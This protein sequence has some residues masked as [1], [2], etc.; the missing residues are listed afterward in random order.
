MEYKL[1]NPTLRVVKI[2]D[3]INNYENG[4][5]F[6]EISTKLK[7]P[8]ST[9]SPIL[10][11]LE[12]T[13]FIEKNDK[14]CY[15]A[16]FKL[17]QLGL[18][19]SGRLDSLSMIKKQMEIVV[20]KIGEIVQFG[21]L[22]DNMV[23]YLEKVNSPDNIEIVSSVGKKIP[24]IYTALGKALLSGF[25]DAEI[26]EK[27]KDYEFVKYTEN[28]ITNIDRLLDEIHKVRERGYAVENQE[29]THNTS[30]VAVPIREDGII[31]G[32]MS[33]TYPI[34]RKT[35]DTEDFISKVLLEQKEIIEDIIKIQNLKLDFTN[36]EQ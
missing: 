33:A 32:A 19:Y 29:F 18:S 11:T 30:C 16:S 28:S 25:S 31:K 12:M 2:L 5:S 1:H 3:L 36:S 22:V 34:F 27:F 10:K 21:V 14:G 24:A 17:F 6:L 13:N 9:L 23:L 8:K 4:L 20:D 7:I 15:M 35:E 26:I